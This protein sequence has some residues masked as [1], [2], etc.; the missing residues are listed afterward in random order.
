MRVDIHQQM[1]NMCTGNCIQHCIFK[2]FHAFSNKRMW[3][4][5]AHLQ[6]HK[7]CECAILEL[8]SI[9]LWKWFL[10]ETFCLLVM[11]RIEQIVWYCNNP[12]LSESLATEACSCKYISRPL[13]YYCQAI[14]L[15]C[16][17]MLIF[18]WPGYLGRWFHANRHATVNASWQKQCFMTP[19][20]WGQNLLLTQ[21]IDG[22]MVSLFGQ[23]TII[24]RR[25]IWWR[26]IL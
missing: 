21:S 24:L 25:I 23:Q 22:R 17:W 3:E 20:L 2:C 16:C 26:P 15:A 7:C 14:Q 19:N 4:T 1:T 12:E 6:D 9:Y 11:S 5:W 8:L 18:L 10:Q 13:L